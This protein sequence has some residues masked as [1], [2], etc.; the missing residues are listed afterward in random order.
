MTH[1]DSKKSQGRLDSFTPSITVNSEKSAGDETDLALLADSSTLDCLR[2]L[3]E[4]VSRI[5]DHFNPPPPD[6]VGTPYI[7]ERLGCTTDYVAVMVREESVPPSCLVPGTGNG[8]PWKFYRS[9]IDQWIE[10]R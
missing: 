10:H 3:V 1:S 4:C 2:R 5:A 6:K 7:A 9:R 8:K